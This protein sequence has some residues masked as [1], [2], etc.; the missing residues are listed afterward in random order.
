MSSTLY[1]FATRAHLCIFLLFPSTTGREGKRHRR[2]SKLAQHATK[3]PWRVVL[4]YLNEKSRRSTTHLLRHQRSPEQE[5]LTA[6][7]NKR[8][9]M[10]W[11]GV[12]LLIALEFEYI[13]RQG[14]RRYTCY[15]ALVVYS[16]ALMLGSSYTVETC[17]CSVNIN[18]AVK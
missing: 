15:V 18:C 11:A 14:T 6:L 17:S 12:R 8:Q 4:L 7:S 5:D 2:V 16:S 10:L 3:I 1:C 13:T 9:S